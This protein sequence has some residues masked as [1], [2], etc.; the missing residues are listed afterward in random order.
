MNLITYPDRDGLVAGLAERMV[1]ALSAAL[2]VRGR[3]TLALAGGTTPGPVFD[4]LSGAD[5]DWS[6]I[7]VLTSD[8]RVVAPH[9]PRANAGLIASRLLRGN[10]SAAKH[11]IWMQDDIDAEAAAV[12]MSAQLAPLLPL[13]VLLLGMGGDMH[14]ASLFPAARGLEAALAEDA[15]PVVALYPDSQPEARLSLSAPVLT[16]ARASFVMMT[17]SEKRVALEA[18]QSLPPEQAP[19]AMMVDRAEFH[20]A[21]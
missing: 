2:S 6:K 12:R 21:E 3:A 19:I 17:G 18:A 13:D 15:P 14:T 16:G 1:S 8:E 20:W 10:A 9:H 4:L 11:L 7:T 5:L